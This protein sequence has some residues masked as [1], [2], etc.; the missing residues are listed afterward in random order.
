VDRL[1]LN[2]LPA[3]AQQQGVTMALYVCLVLAAEFVAVGDHADSEGIVLATIWATT[4][5]LALA[6]VFAFD[7]AGRL[8]S[9]GQRRS[10]AAIAALV[11]LA[12]AIAVAAAV[13]VPFKLLPLDRALDVA[14]FATAALVGVRPTPSHAREVSGT[15]VRSATA[16]SHC[17]SPSSSSASRRCWRRHETIR[18]LLHCAGPLAQSGRATDS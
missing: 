18:R 3:E 17:S 4:I 2:T 10:E 5:G 9:G 8:F 1:G 14:A 6:H 16:R 11:Q 15:T 7:L 13:S 12:A